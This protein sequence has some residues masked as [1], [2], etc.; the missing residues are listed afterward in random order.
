M[1][2][3]VVDIFSIGIGPSSSHTVGPMR[4]AKM[5]MESLPQFPAHV[6][7][8]L[9]GSLAAT[10]KGH[11]TD[12]AVLLG[13]AGWSPLD[14]P[15]DA[16]PA[17]GSIVPSQGEVA[18]GK[19]PPSH[20]CT[21]DITFDSTPVAAHPNCLIFSAWDAEGDAIATDAEFFSVGG[22]FVLTRAEL[23]SEVKATAE[24]PAGMAAA[25]QEI[26]VPYVFSSAAELLTL[27]DKRDKAIW[28]IMLANEEALHH[29]KG[30]VDFVFRH[31]DAVWDVMK[32]CVT[33]GIASEGILPGG[34]SV[35]RRAP[36]LYQRLLA[37]KE[38]G[39]CGFSAMEWVNLYALAVN[40]QN[41]A[42]GRV[43]TAPTNGACGI[44]PAVL[45]YARDFQ[46]AFSRTSARRFLLT[47]GA[48]GMI[49]KQNASISGA[50]VG[51]QG[52]VGSASAMAAAGLAEI[53]GA[54][55]AQV[56][57][58]AEIA[59]EHN[60]GLTCDPVGGLVQI[61]CIE[62]NAIGAVKAINAARLAR[63]GEGSHHVSLDAAI[64]T[65]AET[66]RDMHNKYK[67]TSL[68]GLARTLG[69]SVS[70]VEC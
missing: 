26:A 32:E 10:G 3:S 22:G 35:Q 61:P 24:V 53:M 39:S 29:N 46:S 65:M 30:G 43:V 8:C 18:G 63:V 49:I 55:P 21:Y 57:N 1:T 9:R 62:R 54:S 12:R 6:K 23:E 56:E 15:L 41:A 37:N 58:A 7:I 67:E 68:G 70:Q 48:I 4:A 27:C 31:L 36:K 60:L 11:A 13:L 42:G 59:L 50:E 20:P 66:G 34:L 64:T 69:L 44:I 16:P 19:I 40:E 33:D 51:C 14:V 25:S 45:H 2:I 28:E 52:E 5:F 17:S 47:A 38:D